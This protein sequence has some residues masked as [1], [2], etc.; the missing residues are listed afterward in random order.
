[1]VHSVFHGF[2]VFH[3]LGFHAICDE[4]IWFIT[5]RSTLLW[6]TYQSITSRILVCINTT[7]FEPIGLRAPVLDRSESR[8]YVILTVSSFRVQ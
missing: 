2:R 1:M 5:A 4:E 3:A 6:S 7:M 8:L